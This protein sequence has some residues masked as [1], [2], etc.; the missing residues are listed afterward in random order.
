MAAVLDLLGWAG[1][2]AGCAAILIGTLGLL[3]LPDVF[4]RMHGAGMTDT[5]GAFLLT[6]G[7]MTQ[8][9]DWLVLVKLVAIWL[10]LAFTS[11]ITSHALARAAIHGGC[12]PWTRTGP[13]GRSTEVKEGV[14]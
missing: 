7:M 2:L 3:R 4:T 12:R 1:L 6:L 14:S 9:G 8:T 5:L 13:A 10:F 11:P